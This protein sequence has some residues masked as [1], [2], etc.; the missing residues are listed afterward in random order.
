MEWREISGYDGQYSISEEGCIRSNYRWHIN[1]KTMT[2]H[3]KDRE[4]IMTAN[5]GKSGYARI[6]LSDRKLHFYHQLVALVWVDNPE[7]KPFVNHKDGNKLNNHPSNL[8][9]VTTAE[10]NRHAYQQGL[11][12]GHLRADILA[13]QW[14][15]L[16]PDNEIVSIFNLCKLCREKD[17]SKSSMMAVYK[18]NQYQHKGWKNVRTE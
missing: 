6:K 1:P 10:N 2:R 5:I 17:L 3:R 9:W 16:S 13:H 14:E 8:E 12:S 18:G 4:L 7:N 15:F 11:N